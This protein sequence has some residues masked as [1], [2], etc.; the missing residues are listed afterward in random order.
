[1]WD[2]DYRALCGIIPLLIRSKPTVWDGDY[3]GIYTSSVLANRSKPTVWDGDTR[4]PLLGPL[5]IQEVLSP[6]C[7]M[8]T[9]RAYPFPPDGGRF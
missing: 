6:P 8:V 2:G 5:P 9:Q 3:G 7:G 1:M 4:P